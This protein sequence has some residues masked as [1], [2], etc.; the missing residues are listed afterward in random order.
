MERKK[1]LQ[2]FTMSTVIETN[3]QLYSALRETMQRLI[4]INGN[5][6]DKKSKRA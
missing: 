1:N 2:T 4:N 6:S 3:I 5:R